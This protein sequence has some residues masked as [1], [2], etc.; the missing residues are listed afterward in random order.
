M[1]N[2]NILK[3]NYKLRE[4]GCDPTA[5]W[6]DVSSLEAENSRK[7]EGDDYIRGAVAGPEPPLSPFS[8]G[9][10]PVNPAPLFAAAAPLL[11][12]EVQPCL[13]GSLAAGRLKNPSAPSPKNT[14][15]SSLFTNNSVF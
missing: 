7:A 13:Y 6:H 3:A 9:R 4:G 14:T 11:P 5:Y 12:F 15:T 8:T 2:R 1:F 10:N